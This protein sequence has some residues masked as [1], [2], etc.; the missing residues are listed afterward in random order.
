MTLFHGN[1]ALLDAFRKGERAALTTVYSHYVGEVATLI[2]RGF[3][4]ESR[5]SVLGVREPHRQ[6]DLVQEVFVR[7][8]SESGRMSYDGLSPFR[9]WLLR[10]A[11]N[12]MIDEG[13]RAGTLASS[14]NLQSDE[15]A[16]EILTANP[17]EELE[18]KRL[19]DSTKAWT[20]AQSEEVQRFVRLRFEEER[21]QSEVAQMMGTSRRR[22]RTLESTVRDGLRKHLKSVSL[23]S[24]RAVGRPED[25][26]RT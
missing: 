14:S 6:M 21:P 19:R 16:D 5:G 13:R 17:E 11:K 26:T 18:W 10:I 22:V 15:T 4:M 7:A 20:S 1:R 12:L 23:A 8:F 3:S 24:A 25:P 2:R 9:P